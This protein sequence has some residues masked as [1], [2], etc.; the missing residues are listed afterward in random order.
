MLNPIVN[1]QYGFYLACQWTAFDRVDDSPF[2]DILSLLSSQDT[3]FLI[4]LLAH[5]SLLLWFLLSSS[6]S[7]F[8]NDAGS[9][10]SHLLFSAYTHSLDNI[11][12]SCSFKC[13]PKFSVYFQLESHLSKCLFHVFPWMSYRYPKLDMSKVWTNCSLS[14]FCS[15][16][17]LRI[18]VRK[19]NMMLPEVYKKLI[20]SQSL[21][22]LHI[23]ILVGPNSNLTV[24]QA[25]ITDF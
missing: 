4:F 12:Q 15:C 19:G 9:V 20:F 8:W 1:S 23:P 24:D 3:T 14:H 11:I 7:L 6:I 10:Y 2:P 25:Q 16:L 17:H 22:H 21:F 13:S 18:Y 5:C